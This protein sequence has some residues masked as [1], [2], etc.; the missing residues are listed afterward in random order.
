MTSDKANFEHLKAMFGRAIALSCPITTK[1]LVC[2]NP[3]CAP[4]PTDPVEGNMVTKGP[5]CSNPNCGKF[6]HTL[7]VCPIPTN[8]VEGNISGCFFCN[9]IDHLADDCP[10]MEQ[11]VPAA[12]VTCKLIILFSC[13]PF[14][15]A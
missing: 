2:I 8:H 6:G 12:L 1:G 5:V 4:I 10:M 7:A 11:V 13:L 9:V 14:A 15:V 3:N